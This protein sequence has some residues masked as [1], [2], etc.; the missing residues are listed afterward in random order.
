MYCMKEYTKLIRHLERSHGK[1]KEVKE[2]EAMAKNSIERKKKCLLMQNQGNFKHNIQ[3]IKDLKGNL[4]VVRR[5]PHATRSYKV[6]YLYL[7]I[8]INACF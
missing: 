1:E 2:I 7:C 4:K 5:P 8:S 3:V 6:I